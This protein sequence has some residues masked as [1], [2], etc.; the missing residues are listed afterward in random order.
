MA[1]IV[2]VGAGIGGLSAALLLGREGHHVIVCERDPAPVPDGNDAVW[3][4]WPRPGIPQSRLGHAFL[5]GFRSLLAEHLPD[6][7]ADILASG[8]P[9]VDE[10]RDM[11]GN[12]RTAADAE[13]VTIMCRRPV[14]EA[15]F[16]RAAVREPA[17]ELRAGCQVTGLAADC[18]DDGP[19]RV[20]GVI[21]RAGAIPADHVVLSGGRL[22]LAPALFA[23]VG[24]TL[25]EQSVRCGFIC[26][27]RYF[28]IHTHEGQDERVA[29][30]LTVHADAGY[31][32]YEMWGADSATF[33][34][35]L[36]VPAV[37]REFR[38]LRH[39]PAW[40]AA[41]LAL[42][43]CTEWISP[44]R[45]SP[46]SAI[47]AMG[48]ERNTLRQFVRD[49]RPAALGVHVIGD[50]RCQTNS[51]YAWGSRQALAA[52]CAVRDVIAEHGGDP[53]AQALALDLRLRPELAGRFK[54]SRQF[55]QAWHQASRAEPEWATV[56]D[57]PGLMA[58]VLTPAAD[59]DAEVFRAVM[60]WYLQLDPVDAI[61]ANHEVV[62][63]A[64]AVMATGP[65]AVNEPSR[66]G[67]DDLLEIAGA[68]LRVAS[69][70][71]DL[72]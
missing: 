22:S 70:P 60:R 6:V 56:E 1:E 59:H 45:S 46:I 55:D 26:Y 13:L 35:E 29:T 72:G 33:C 32:Q 20:T 4:D 52:A 63:R 30:Q 62:E 14:L 69:R 43:E 71:S 2:I 25:E 21:T 53:E 41:A 10:A 23:E 68:A 38:C 3:S 37:D 67:R 7:L 34:V 49:G 12:E 31:M 24:A 36:L 28:R 61:Y 47:A 16:R 42:P 66:P 15:A 18:H 9:E 51:A 57:G 54:H 11:P 58:K 39:E 27:T 44:D 19:P 48:G 65:Q 17:I 50:A 5:P 64:R 8:A 40:T